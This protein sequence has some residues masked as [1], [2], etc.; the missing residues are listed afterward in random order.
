MD[1]LDTN[2]QWKFSENLD[3]LIEQKISLVII[4]FISVP[5]YLGLWNDM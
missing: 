3:V 4:F 5:P 2:R 1:S